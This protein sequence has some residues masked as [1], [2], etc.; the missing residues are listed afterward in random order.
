V[1]SESGRGS[2]FTVVLPLKPDGPD[3]R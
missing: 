2:V 1:S 3:A